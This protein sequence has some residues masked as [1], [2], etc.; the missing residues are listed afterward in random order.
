LK[1]AR[2]KEGITQEALAEMTGIRQ[3]HISEIENHKRPIGKKNA[4]KPARALKASLKIFLWETIAA[5]PSRGNRPLRPAPLC[6]PSSGGDRIGRGR[7][8]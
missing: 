8:F 4:V 2:T 7:R 3:H 1:G 6:D 5:A